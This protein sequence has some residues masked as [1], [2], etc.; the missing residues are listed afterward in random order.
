[1][2]C[3]GL[4]ADRPALLEAVSNRA[5]GAQI[6]AHS[7][8]DRQRGHFIAFLTGLAMFAVGILGYLAGVVMGWPV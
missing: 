5:G 7:M 4:Q 3:G 8:T 6:G 2:R 1:M